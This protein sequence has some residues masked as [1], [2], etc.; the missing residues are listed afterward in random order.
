MR[1]KQTEWIDIVDNTISELVHD[2]TRLYKYYNYYNGVM[3]KEQYRHLEE[4]YGLGNPTSIEF[5]PLISKH[6]DAII[7][8]YLE[9]PILPKITCKD[10]KTLKNIERDRHLKVLTDVFTYLQNHLNNNLLSV[11]KG[12]NT[13]DVS[14]QQQITEIIE[15]VESNFISEYEIAAQ[16]MIKYIMAS[17]D[18]DIHEKLR[19]L[20]LDLLIGGEV[21]FRVI[22]SLEGNNIDLRVEDPLNTFVERVSKSNYVNKAKRAVIREW[23]TEEEILAEYHNDL[24]NENKKLL[25]DC[26]VYSEQQANA[27]VRTYDDVPVGGEGL[28]ANDEITPGLPDENSIHRNLIPVYTVEIIETD[29]KGVQQRYVQKRIG[30]EIYIIDLDPIDVIRTMSAPQLCTLELNG[31]FFRTRGRSNYSLVE[32]CMVLQ[33]KFN[34]LHFFRDNLLASGGTIGDIVDV[35]KLPDFL[36]TTIPEKIQKFFAYKKG[37]TYL[38]DSSLET[39]NNGDN[40]H[41]GGFD[42]TIKGEAIQAIEIAIERIENTCSSITGVFRERLNGIQQK[43]AVSNIKV[44][45][46]NSFTITKKFT[47]QMDLVTTSILID[48]L[49]KAKKVFKKGLTGSIILGEKYQKIFTALPEHFTITDFDITIEPTTNVLKDIEIIKQ[50]IPELIKAQAIDADDAIYAL[51]MQSLSQLHK[52]LGKSIKRKKGIN[53]QFV[54]AQQQIEQLQQQLQQLADE[55]KALN[56]KIQSLNADKIQVEREKMQL[57]NNLKWFVARADKDAKEKK[58]ATDDKKVEVEYAQLFDGNPYN[59]KVNWNK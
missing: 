7:G 45:I 21:Y 3:D 46:Q 27:Y 30:H 22:E 19:C 5:I 50:F 52:E 41:Y 51:T 53:E 15:D 2:K 26:K 55:N 58:A 57:D 56:E 20:F 48:C 54:Q 29:S 49:N 24:S 34:I 36:G 11:L 17:R 8:E 39:A 10:E 37:G 6:I 9:T 44:G 35:A 4:N 28:R 1:K 14:V 18:I 59:D 38:I 42:D 31:L 43:D 25:R 12:G 40:T 33:D 16:N 47:H 32:A 13:S 23:L